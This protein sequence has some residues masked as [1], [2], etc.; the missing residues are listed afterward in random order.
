[1]KQTVL[2]GVLLVLIASFPAYA[3]SLV[4][5][6]CEEE[7]TGTEV[8][9]NG[10]FVGECPVD[11][12]VNEGTVLLRARKAVNGD[13]EKIFEKKLRVVEGVSQRVELVMSAPQLTADAKFRKEA[14]EAGVQL[15][16]AEAGDI[17]AMKKMARR[18][19]AGIGVKKDRA[20]AES[21]R[22]KAEAT[23]AQRELNAA[24]SGAIDAML[25]MAARY[26]TGLGVVKDPSQA[27]AW[28][29][30]AADA[31]REKIERDN[32]S[33]AVQKAQ[34]K[35]A[36]IDRVSFFEFTKKTFDFKEGF[37]VFGPFYLTLM[38]TATAELPLFDLTSAPSKTTELNKLKNEAA[39]LPSSWGKP[40]SMIA[41]ASL[42][43]KS[44]SATAE[45]SLLLAAAK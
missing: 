36:K 1:M 19:D 9:L 16:T 6:Q 42:Q 38:P 18:Y 30:K 45:N 25:N 32:A 14:A 4:R 10:K 7:D 35:Q 12:P 15:R 41:R 29:E 24:R 31:Q 34:E 43:L 37:A 44:N 28:R 13:Y 17:D 33:L 21:W 39:L 11:A 27:E 40:D 8:Y 3:D 5:V 26:S 22:D 20:Q 2:I 23:A